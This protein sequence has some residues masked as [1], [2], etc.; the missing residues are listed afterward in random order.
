MSNDIQLTT[1]ESF[2]PSNIIFDTCQKRTIPNSEVCYHQINI[3]YRYPDGSKGP[4]IFQLPRCPT[5]GVSNKYGDDADK[6]SL[7]IVLGDRTN[8]TDEYKRAVTV[9]NDVVTSI[10]QHILTDAVKNKLGQFDLEERDLKDISFLRPSKDKD[11]KKPYPML[12]VP[13][14]M[15]I[16]FMSRKNKETGI[17]EIYSTICDE[18]VCNARG[19]PQPVDP[20]EFVSKVGSV[21]ALIKVESIYFGTKY[22]IQTKVYQADIKCNGN[23]YKSLIQRSQTIAPVFAS[24]PPMDDYASDNDADDEEVAAVN[25]KPQIM[26]E[27]SG[28]EDEDEELPT[29]PQTPPQPSP[30]AASTV[31][32]KGGRRPVKK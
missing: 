15:N 6:I 3:S 1:F 25:T 21:V 12:E 28:K 31:G 30:P 22:K 23:S 27:D 2:K 19:E 7:S 14:S 17:K 4:L 8:Y 13:P 18:N 10:K 32:A 20:R 26:D 9:L 16:K 5:F 11:T 24:A 29:R